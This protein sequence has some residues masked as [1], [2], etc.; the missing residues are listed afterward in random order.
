MRVNSRS[1]KDWV[2]DTFRGVVRLP[3]FQ[4]EESWKK[5]MV[6]KFLTTLI[7][8]SRPVG[9]LLVLETDS[10][11][12]GFAT[13]PIS[14]F[15]EFNRD[16]EKCTSYLLDGQQRITA[17]LRAFHDNYEKETYYIRFR[18]DG[19]RYELASIL[20]LEDEDMGVVV[21]SK[22]VQWYRSPK[23]EYQNGLFPIRLLNP[24]GE[25]SY[26]KWVRE[27]Q[28]NDEFIEFIIDNTQKSWS[29][30]D[31]FR[32]KLWISSHFECIYRKTPCKV[33][34]IISGASTVFDDH[35]YTDE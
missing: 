15:P 30:R 10:S 22:N 16:S 11:Q 7:Y 35:I 24:E 8:K 4:R 17:L 29:F 12:D 33:I 9:V 3:S 5:N 6:R 13:K 26:M 32:S 19:R 2:R 18:N 1:V 31:S 20:D 27:A 14:G 25:P 34:M 23:E 21:H 28:C